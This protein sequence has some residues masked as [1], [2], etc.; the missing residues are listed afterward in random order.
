MGDEMIP[1]F[2]TAPEKE[3]IA[4]LETGDRMAVLRVIHQSPVD[5]FL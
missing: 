4:A 2:K 5:L 1:L 3:R